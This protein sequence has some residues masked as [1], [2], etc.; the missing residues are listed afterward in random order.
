MGT[1]KEY[2]IQISSSGYTVNK[3]TI[4]TAGEKN[5]IELNKDTYLTKETVKMTVSDSAALLMIVMK[6]IFYEFDKFRL[7]E[8][9]KRELDKYVLYFNQYPNMTV[10]INS[11]T[12]ARGTASYNQKLSEQRAESVVNYFISR[13]INPARLSWR[14]YG[15]DQLSVPNA[16]LEA[17]HQANRR[18]VFKILSLGAGINIEVKHITAL[19]ML[20][21]PQGVVDM[22]GWWLQIH[23]STSSR[24]LELP[25]IKYA[26]RVTGKEVRLIRCDDGKYRYC[27][28]Y[29]TRNEALKI[30]LSLLKDNI[31]TLLMRF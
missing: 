19:E 18:T 27:I 9:S 5:F 10:E 8:L 3:Q 17:E 26:E 30:Q 12:D 23:E 22:S 25:I 1:D 21:E 11:H 2:A 7:T 16:R 4:S 29:T 24:E 15:K 20:N 31:H 6:D 14:G 28:Q 13:G